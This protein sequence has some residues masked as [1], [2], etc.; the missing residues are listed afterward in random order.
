MCLYSATCQLGE[1]VDL[2]WNAFIL[3]AKEVSLGSN[4]TRLS[5]LIK[6]GRLV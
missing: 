1:S 2:L 5:G 3:G 4:G 6:L